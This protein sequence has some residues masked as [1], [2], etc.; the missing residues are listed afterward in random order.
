MADSNSSVLLALGVAAD[1]TLELLENPEGAFELLVDIGLFHI[2][3]PWGKVA[4]LYELRAFFRDTLRT[5]R[6][7]D[8][9]VEPGRWTYAE[10]PVF[11]L[12]QYAGLDVVVEKDSKY[13]DRYFLCVGEALRFT[14]TVQQTDQLVEALES[15]LR[16]LD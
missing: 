8:V 1:V 9:E 11:Q 14:P 4:S 7:L 13:D 15:L 5:G 10:R 12:G 6:H 2:T 3:L 16:D